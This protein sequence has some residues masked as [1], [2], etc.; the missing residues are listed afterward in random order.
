MDCG[1][2]TACGDQVTAVRR[3][4][5]CKRHQSLLFFFFFFFSYEAINTVAKIAQ[6]NNFIYFVGDGR[7]FKLHV[8]NWWG[9]VLLCS[10]IA[11]AFVLLTE[12]TFLAGMLAAQLRPQL[13]LYFCVTVCYDVTMG[14][15]AQL[16]VTVRMS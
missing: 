10:E 7:K 3:T 1:S 2:P 4:P 11:S 13:F 15:P 9:R 5:G 12:I 8:K 6:T 14:K 16:L